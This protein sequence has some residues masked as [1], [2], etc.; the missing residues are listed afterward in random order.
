MN[1]IGKITAISLTRT[2]MGPIYQEMDAATEVASHDIAILLFLLND[3]PIIVNAWGSSRLG[4]N[5]QDS[6]NIIIGYENSLKPI[7]NVQWTSVIRERTI[8]LEGTSGTIICKTNQGKEELTIYN[9]HTAFESMKNGAKLQEIMLLVKSEEVKL[10]ETEPLYDE[11]QNFLHCIENNLDPVTNFDFSR[12]VVS[13]SEAIRKSMKLNG[14]TVN[15]S[16]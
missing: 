5:Y 12:K 10:S 8:V 13:V 3:L 16:W 4:L 2:H 11:L 14:Q 7:I 9:Q 15:I 6:A 1:S